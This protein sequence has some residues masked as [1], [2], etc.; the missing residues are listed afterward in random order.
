MFKKPICVVTGPLRHCR[1][2][3]E[4]ASSAALP[5][6]R[7]WGFLNMLLPEHSKTAQDPHLR[8]L[9]CTPMSEALQMETPVDK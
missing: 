9:H 6:P 7:I 8:K 1:R 2:T 5:A 3:N 4:Y